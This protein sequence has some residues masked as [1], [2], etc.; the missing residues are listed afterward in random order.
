MNR[1]FTG[2]K[3]WELTIGRGRRVRLYR[4]LPPSSGRAITNSACGNLIFVAGSKQY[5][6][7]NLVASLFYSL[8]CPVGELLRKQR[9]RL[10][11]QPIPDDRCMTNNPQ[12][13]CELHGSLATPRQYSSNR[14]FKGG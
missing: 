1:T 10:P 12:L 14:E 4:D 11:G 3:D 13:G 9:L 7:I 6:G 2:G 5:V 8:G